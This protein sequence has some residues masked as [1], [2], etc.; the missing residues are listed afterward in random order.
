MQTSVL[1]QSHAEFTAILTPGEDGFVAS[2]AEVPGT[3]TEAATE[4]EALENLVDAVSIV[5]EV[6]RNEAVRDAPAGAKHYRI[7][8][9]L[10]QSQLLNA[11]EEQAAISS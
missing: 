3:Q 11:N 2:C 9:D 5:F 4:R 6:N 1:P 7:S 8:V 10:D